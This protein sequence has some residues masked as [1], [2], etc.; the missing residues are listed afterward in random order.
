MINGQAVILDMTAGEMHMIPSLSFGVDGFGGTPSATTS[1]G[2]DNIAG[3]VGAM[4][5]VARGLA[6]LITES[7][8]VPPPW[9]RIS[10]AAMNGLCR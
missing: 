8:G 1:F 3:A 10:V 4:A 9:E 7:A 6:G 5:S 2:G